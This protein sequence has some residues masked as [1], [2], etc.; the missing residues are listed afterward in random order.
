MFTPDTLAAVIDAGHVRIQT[1]PS[2][3]L[4]IYNYTEQCAYEGAW[5]DVTLACRGL[6]IDS[7]TGAVVARPFAKFF[8]HGQAGA[9]SIALDE[10]VTV[11]DK[12]D[13]SLGI[14]YPTPAGPAVATRGSFA[15]AQAERATTLLRT[16]YP[17]WTPPAGV[18]V[19][20]EII[21]P[22]NRIVIDYGDMADLVLLGAV[23][24]ATGR[25]V[26]VR[27]WPGPV[28][29][30]FAY[31]T[32]GEAL[33]APARP[34]R[35]GLVV[36]VPATG[37]R[38]KLKYEEYVRLHRI[39]TGLTS[40][41]IWEAL[42]AGT[43]LADICAPLPDEFHGWA[44]EVAARFEREIADRLAEVE[45]TFTSIVA[46]LPEGHSRKDFALTAARHDLRGLLFARL[47]GHD[48]RPAI[49]QQIKPPP[50]ETPNNRLFDG[51]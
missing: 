31:R 14:V 5:N 47:D 1:H 35:E 49:W 44:R 11:T 9:P 27:D 33:A 20:V 43:P 16:R 45:R 50:G 25:T 30:T 36:H 8:N 34:N 37:D 4:V 24:I 17:G 26:G 21:Y 2:L 41:T 29:E 6:I 51:E 18:T 23:E 32:F 3:P 46:S 42:A 7:V 12:A 10:P 48:L 22:E 13:G 39:V 15:S 40:R 38:V 28:V 19:L